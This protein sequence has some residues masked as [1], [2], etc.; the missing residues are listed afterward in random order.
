IAV[1]APGSRRWSRSN[2]RRRAVRSENRT[3]ARRRSGRQ[4]PED[5]WRPQC[6][7]ALYLLD[8]NAA[9]LVGY[10]IE[11]VGDLLQVIVD[12]DTDNEVHGVG[13]AVLQEKLLQADIVQ[14]IDTAFQLAQ[15]LGDCDQ[16]RD[17][18]ADRLQ[19]RQRPMD[20][21]GTFYDQRT[22]L[23]HRRLKAEHLEQH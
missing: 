22:Y 7:P 1:A 10:V 23:T 9:D 8:D 15:F 21:I 11:A 3:A 2:S 18:V 14:I 19:Q 12:L 16:H 13:V 5:Q 20:Q 4:G 17:V 6:G